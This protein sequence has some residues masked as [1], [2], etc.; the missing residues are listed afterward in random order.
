MFTLGERRVG[1]SDR[2][3]VEA[4][5]EDTGSNKLGKTSATAGSL[6]ACDFTTARDY[7]TACHTN[8]GSDYRFRVCVG[9]KRVFGGRERSLMD[10]GRGEDELWLVF[11]SVHFHSCF[12]FMLCRI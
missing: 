10:D 5:L 9:V 1:E 11:F 6:K 4:T 2:S 3:C 12:I 8:Y 7:G